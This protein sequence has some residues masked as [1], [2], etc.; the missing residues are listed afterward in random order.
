MELARTGENLS[1]QEQKSHWSDQCWV[2]VR[3][4]LSPVLQALVG[5]APTQQPASHL[6][7]S[8]QKNL[9]MKIIHFDTEKQKVER[10]VFVCSVLMKSRS[11][12]YMSESDQR[13]TPLVLPR[14]KLSLKL[15]LIITLHRLNVSIFFANRFVHLNHFWQ[16]KKQDK[17]KTRRSFHLACTT[18]TLIITLLIK[19]LHMH[20]IQIVKHFCFNTKH[21][22]ECVY[23]R[24][25]QCSW[26]RD[27]ERESKRRE[28]RK[29]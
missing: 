1:W 17:K 13:S 24:K 22:W 19:T 5:G 15:I 28:N 4:S 26:R 25:G 27:E 12:L 3:C 9:T 10:I 23:L 18:N 2:T 11:G 8:K 6:R 14:L 20:F 16:L 29:Q 7:R 21:P